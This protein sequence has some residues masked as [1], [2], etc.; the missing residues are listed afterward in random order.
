MEI[1]YR[2]FYKKKICRIKLFLDEIHLWKVTLKKLISFLAS[3]LRLL[4][5]WTMT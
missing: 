2:K 3:F 1:K 5:T 4:K